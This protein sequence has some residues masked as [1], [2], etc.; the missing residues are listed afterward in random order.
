MRRLNYFTAGRLSENPGF[1]KISRKKRERTFSAPPVIG[2]ASREQFDSSYGF[3]A[4]AGKNVGFPL[5]AFQGGHS[6]R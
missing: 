6:Q 4:I 1:E 2:V 3:P 5:I